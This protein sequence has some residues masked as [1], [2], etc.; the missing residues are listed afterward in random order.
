MVDTWIAMIEEAADLLKKKATRLKVA[1]G[2]LAAAVV[3]VAAGF[4]LH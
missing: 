1:M 2:T 4:P 3:L